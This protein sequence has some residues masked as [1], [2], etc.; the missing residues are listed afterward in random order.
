M[1]R[2]IQVLKIETKRI[3]DVVAFSRKMSEERG[4]AQLARRVTITK[5]RDRKNTYRF[6]VEFD[7]FEDAMK[8][9]NDPATQKYAKEMRKLL[10]KAPKFLNL[11]VRDVLTFP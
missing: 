5:D 4:D 9:S 8:N 3:D 10:T 6:I 2:F 1:A 11:D 7:S